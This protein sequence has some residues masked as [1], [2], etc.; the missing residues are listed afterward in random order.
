MRLLIYS[1]VIPTN[2]Y[3]PGIPQK[4]ASDSTG[5]DINGSIGQGAKGVFPG[6]RRAFDLG[7]IAIEYRSG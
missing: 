3:L 2:A 4:V 5:G 7:I 6:N 1:I